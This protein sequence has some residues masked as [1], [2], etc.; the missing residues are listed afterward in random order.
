MVEEKKYNA[1][2][3]F[4]DKFESKEAELKYY[5]NNFKEEFLNTIIKYII[6]EHINQIFSS[7]SSFF[8][9]KNYNEF[10]SIKIHTCWN[11]YK[12]NNQNIAFSFENINTYSEYTDPIIIE[13]M[14][15]FYECIL[16]VL[17]TY[18]TRLNIVD[19]NEKIICDVNNGVSIEFDTTI[20]NLIEIIRTERVNELD[21]KIAINKKIKNNYDEWLENVYIKI[22]HKGFLDQFWKKLMDIYYSEDRN[23]NPSVIIK[24]SDDEEPLFNLQETKLDYYKTGKY[25][26]SFVIKIS[27]KYYEYVRDYIRNFIKEYYNYNKSNDFDE[28]MYQL[29]SG[30]DIEIE[31]FGDNWTEFNLDDIDRMQEMYSLEKKKLAE[32]NETSPNKRHILTLSLYK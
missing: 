5:E 12:T 22:F 32:I 6:D 10:C 2:Y 23:G 7:L 16:S 24:K 9:F 31:K 15:I 29:F 19:K 17:K 13:T 25:H 4:C 18:A 26:Y 27:S 14:P 21:Y 8:Y 11:V 1:Y 30:L 28:R 3:N 20:G